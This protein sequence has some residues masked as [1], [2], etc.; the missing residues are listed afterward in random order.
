MRNELEREILLY[1]QYQR[2]QRAL[3]ATKLREFT[4]RNALVAWD[5]MTK[6]LKVRAYRAVVDG[7]DEVWSE[8]IVKAVY[9]SCTQEID[10]LRAEKSNEA[11]DPEL[12]LVTGFVHMVVLLY[13]DSSL[14]MRSL[15]G[16]EACLRAQRCTEV[17]PDYLCGVCTG[18]VAM[19]SSGEVYVAE[20]FRDLEGDGFAD[21][22]G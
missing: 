11:F 1:D 22:G 19:Q 8:D 5:A 9:C 14:D 18:E 7:E 2:E 10:R 21:Q 15:Q 6:K 20:V 3:E 17:E 13:A 4:K 16:Q 12:N